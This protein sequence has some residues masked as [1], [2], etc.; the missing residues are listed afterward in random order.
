LF[1]DESVF[2]YE[3]VPAQV[4]HRETELNVMRSAIKPL[5]QGRKGGNLFIYGPSG[6]GKTLSS[7]YVLNKLRE[8]VSG[9]KP[10][11]VNCW[12][13]Q[14]GHASF[15]EL[16]RQLMIPLPSKGLSTEFIRDK[17]F[18]KLRNFKGV[19]IVLDEVDKSEDQG[20]IYSLVEEL[21]SKASLFLVT[22]E[23]GFIT[24][25]DARI[26]SRLCL[27]D[28]EFR[29]Y[30]LDQV[31]EILMERARYGFVPGVIKEELVDMI[32]ETVF[33][34]GDVR[35]GLFLLRKAGRLAEKSASRV[36]TESH[37]KEALDSLNDFKEEVTPL[38][39]VERE[40][41]NLIK[42]REGEITGF[43][44]KEY[45]VK[46]K[47]VS[48]RYFTKVVNELVSKGFVKAKE[49]NTGFRGRSRVL[50]LNKE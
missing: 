4:L 28:L 35:I 30:S 50:T 15:L 2:D 34:K 26:R 1:K 39:S 19:V 33:E 25:L 22:N 21:G 23:R 44:Y 12:K 16:A 3:Y 29:A 8:E 49:T 14:G 9:V 18:N 38:S 46:Y 10:L 20:F 43:Y 5:I 31:K 45:R 7:V 24:R 36:I 40:V 17:V 6:V 27:E 13:T 48:K 47:P 11:F 37:V 41:L 32:S 42:K